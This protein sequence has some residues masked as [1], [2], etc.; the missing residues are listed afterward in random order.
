MFGSRVG[1]LGEVVDAVVDALGAEFFNEAEGFEGAFEFSAIVA[2]ELHVFDGVF[3]ILPAVDDDG[4]PEF[5]L[6]VFV[7]VEDAAAGRGEHPFVEAAGED[8]ATEVVDAEGDLPCEVCAVYYGD[9]AFGAGG[10]ADLLDREEQAGVGGDAGER[11]DAGLG[12]DLGEQ[13]FGD[14]IGVVGRDRN[15]SFANLDAGAGLFEEPAAAAG[16]VFLIGDEDFVAGLE[17]E[18][19]GDEAHRFCGV[20]GECEFFFGGAEEFG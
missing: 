14:L 17:V 20:V 1:V 16:G 10:G 8:V 7:D 11:D 4:G 18:T 15:F 12:A 3:R 2:A 9:D 13:G 19:V 6:E 5:G